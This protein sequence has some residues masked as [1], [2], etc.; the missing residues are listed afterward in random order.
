MTL[1]VIMYVGALSVLVSRSSH[2]FNLKMIWILIV[3]N[4]KKDFIRHAEF[5]LFNKKMLMYNLFKIIFLHNLHI[6]VCASA[7]KSRKY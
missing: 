6:I 3:K 4:S 7:N 1:E 2:R 5:N